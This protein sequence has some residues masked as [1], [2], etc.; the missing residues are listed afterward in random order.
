M[1]NPAWTQTGEA[2]KGFWSNAVSIPETGR[3]PIAFD[4]CRGFLQAM[5]DAQAWIWF[6]KLVVAGE[7]LVGVALILGAFTGIAAFVGGFMNWNFMLAGSAG[8]NPVFFVLSVG[9]LLAWKVGGYFGLDYFLLAWLGT[10]WKDR[11]G[12]SPTIGVP[13]ARPETVRTRARA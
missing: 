7:V 8:V 11:P 4:W 5:L 6:S 3:P 12:E 9:L 2:P 10:P 13:R 1:S